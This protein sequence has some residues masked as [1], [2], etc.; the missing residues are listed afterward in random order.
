MQYLDCFVGMTTQEIGQAVTTHSLS[1]LCPFAFDENS[2]SMQCISTESG[3]VVNYDLD[4]KEV[5]EDLKMNYGQY[6]ESIR[7]KLLAGKLM[8]EEGLGLV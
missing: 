1:G 4:E 5:D 3:N 8:Y 7:D 2:N 6:I